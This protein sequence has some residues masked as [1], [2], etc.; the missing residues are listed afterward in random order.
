MVTQGIRFSIGALLGLVS[1]ALILLLVVG[2][3][4][5]MMA[6]WRSDLDRITTMAAE[7]MIVTSAFYAIPIHARWLRRAWVVEAWMQ[8]LCRD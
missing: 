3:G 5:V 6:I 4:A 2:Y 8:R 1:A 7:A